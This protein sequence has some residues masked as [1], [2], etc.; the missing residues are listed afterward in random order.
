MEK[1]KRTKKLYTA[2]KKYEESIFFGND[3]ITK[4]LIKKARKSSYEK[5]KVF[6][7]FYNNLGDVNIEAE[8]VIIPTYVPFVEKKRDIDRSSLFSFSG[9][10][11]LL[12][13]DMHT[14]DFLLNQ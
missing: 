9:P 14:L 7:N 4:Q 5:D 11:E 2:L 10:F 6:M 1:I 8:E 12:H 13:A 3:K